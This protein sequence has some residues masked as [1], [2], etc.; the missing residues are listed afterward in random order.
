MQKSNLQRLDRI[1]FVGDLLGGSL[2]D[3]RNDDVD[4]QRQEEAGYERVQSGSGSDGVAVYQGEIV[5][6]DDGERTDGHTADSACEVRALPEQR[7]QDDRAEGGAKA[8]PCVGNQSHDAGIGIERDQERDDR[9]DYDGDLADEQGALLGSVLLDNALV[10]ILGDCGS[11]DEQL[12]VGG[13][14]DRREDSAEEDAA[15]EDQHAVVG[16]DLL[17]QADEGGFAVACVK[18]LAEIASGE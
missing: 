14:H 2:G 13:G 11:G 18:L 1:E 9:D 7:K 4:D 10:H 5:P 16:E 12:A 3:E 15:D 8:C 17:D 6:Y